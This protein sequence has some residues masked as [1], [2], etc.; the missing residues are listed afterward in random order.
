MSK[1]EEKKKEEELME[2]VAADAAELE[3]EAEEISELDMLQ[4]QLAELEAESARNLDGWQRAQAEFVNY[5]KRVERDQSRMY[6]EAAARIIK[7]VL[8][9]IDDFN[10]ALQDRPTEGEAGEWANGM[11]LIFRKMQTI[12]ESENV[13]LMQVEG[14]MFDPNLHEAISQVESPEHQSGQ[15]VEVIQQGYMI[16]DRVLRAALVRVAS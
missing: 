6:E 1:K 14:E 7:R 2:D 8:P 16:G 13:T 10:R 15:I 12:L 3:A 5:R 4:Q 11:E 9:V